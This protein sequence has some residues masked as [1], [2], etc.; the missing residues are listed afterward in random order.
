MIYPHYWNTLLLGNR[1]GV[2][3]AIQSWLQLDIDGDQTLEEVH[4]RVSH[5]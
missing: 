3:T 1:S 2:D 5:E 4:F